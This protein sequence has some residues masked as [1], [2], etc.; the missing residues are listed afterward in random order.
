MGVLTL[1]SCTQYRVAIHTLSG[2][3]LYIVEK[4]KRLGWVEIDG[5][6]TTSLDDALKTI[7]L[8]QINSNL[9]VEYIKIK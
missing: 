4:R 5:T 2:Q 8:Y 3:K 6:V 7:N 1:Q 9:N